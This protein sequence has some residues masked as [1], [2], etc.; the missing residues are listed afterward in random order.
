MLQ[1]DVTNAAELDAVFDAVA[2]RYGRL[3]T[4][5]HSVAFA[6]RA[7]LSGR[8]VDVSREGM[9]GGDRCIGAELD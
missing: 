4:L 7:S 6:D 3:D 9:L 5:V 8:F 2:E 1:A